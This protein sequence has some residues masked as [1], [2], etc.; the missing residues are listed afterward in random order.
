LPHEKVAGEVYDQRRSAA[1]MASLAEGIQSLVS[2][3]RQEQQ[4]IR[5]WVNAQAA[6]Q[7]DIRKLLRRLTSER[8]TH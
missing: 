3:M 2:H 6:Q 7:E 8:E 5:D 1:A 4:Q